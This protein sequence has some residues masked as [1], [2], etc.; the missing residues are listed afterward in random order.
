MKN[1]IRTNNSTF[2]KLKLSKKV[3]TPEV[4]NRIRSDIIQSNLKKN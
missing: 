1:R 2:T 4:Y 3:K